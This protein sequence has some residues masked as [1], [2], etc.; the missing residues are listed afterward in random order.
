MTAT[1]QVDGKISVTGN[2]IDL[3]PALHDYVVEKLGKVLSKHQQLVTRVDVH[4]RVLRNPSIQ[5]NHSAEVVVQ[6]KGNVLRSE[7]KSEG[8][9][10]SI[11]MVSDKVGRT[12]RKYKERHLVRNGPKISTFVQ[13]EE[14]DSEAEDVI[15]DVDSLEDE[16]GVPRVTQIVKKKSFPMPAQTVEE[17]V[18]CL[19]YIDH[20][21][22]VFRNKE[23]KEINVVY[24]RKGN[25]GVGLIEPKD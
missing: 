16:N 4:L 24:K 17:A 10:G 15:S 14:T 12:L 11:D 13:G 19:E 1:P 25:D 23:T 8:M 3:T 9:Y 18:L 21:F 5:H 22:Y 20:P 6:V 7:V 2:N